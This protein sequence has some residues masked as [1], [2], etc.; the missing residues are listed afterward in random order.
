MLISLNICPL[1]LPWNAKLVSRVF[2]LHL[3]DIYFGG[4]VIIRSPDAILGNSDCLHNAR[5]PLRRCAINPLGPWEGCQNLE[6]ASSL[7]L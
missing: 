6:P 2:I 7:R 5:S 4:K 3:S 1:S